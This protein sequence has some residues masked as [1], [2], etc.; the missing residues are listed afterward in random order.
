MTLDELNGLLVGIKGYRF[1]NYAATAPL[2]KPS[3][4]EMIRILTQGLQPLSFHFDDWLSHLESARRL[5]AETINAFPDEIA[6]VTNTSSALSLIAASLNLKPKDRIFY[7]ADDFPSNR[8]VWIN[9]KKLGVEAEAFHLQPGKD[10]VTQLSTWD[11]SRVRLISI[12][13]VSF[14][15]GRRFD[16]AHLSRFC[17]EKGML[18]AVD[19]IQAVGAIP[20]DVHQWDCDF[21]ACG[22]Q[23]WLLGPVGSGFL[24]IAKHLL[25][26][27]HMPLVGWASVKSA[28]DFNEQRFDFV[29]GARR[30][31][32]GLPD[33]AAIAGLAKSLEI[34][35]LV[36]WKNVFHRIS[37]HNLTLQKELKNIGL[38]PLHQGPPETQSGIVTIKLTPEET[39]VI[40]EIF[41]Q[42]KIILT[43]RN[44]TL[45]ISAHAT[46][47]HED[48]IFLLDILSQIKKKKFKPSQTEE[49]VFPSIKSNTQSKPGFQN[50]LIT[51]ATRGLGEAL[52]HA[53]AKRGCHLTLLGRDQNKLKEISDDLK[54]RYRIQVKT[55][56]L[57]LSD[58]KALEAWLLENQ[59]KL[60]SFDVLINNA[61][62]AQTDLFSESDLKDVRR[63]FETNF[64]SPISL[65]KKILPGMIERKSGWILNIITSGARCGLPLFSSY[66]SSKGAFWTFSETLT[67]ELKTMGIVVTS[68]LPPHMGTSTYRQIGRKALAYYRWRPASSLTS[69][70]DFVAEQAIQA[71]EQRKTFV[72][73]LSTKLKLAINALLP[74]VITQ[75]ILRHCKKE[76]R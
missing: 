35:S 53:L 18:L 73:P 52:S 54:S 2:L 58:P 46:T 70:P 32:A 65:I 33:I 51:G 59:D 30:L 62:E 8:Y 71:L 20:V 67:R 66:A 14:N 24:Y 28:G 23:K 50:A 21:L 19:G 72:G 56:I 69:S 11:L 36:G 39:E 40:Q 13:A 47:R 63:S 16:V 7:P 5:V 45:R 64:F 17:H 29:D 10:L 75:Q 41:Q 57:D 22:G 9:L 26:E 68:F 3:C 4:D 76:R 38:P 27:L 1:F 15:D 48:I 60:W 37:E 49:I 25:G 6:F 55:V 12:S 43:L 44:C 74:E 61:A 42:H 34:L 31:E